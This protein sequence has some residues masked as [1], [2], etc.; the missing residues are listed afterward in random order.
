VQTAR[1]LYELAQQG[2]TVVFATH[3]NALIEQFPGRVFECRGNQLISH[4]GPITTAGADATTPAEAAVGGFP[5]DTPAD[6]PTPDSAPGASPADDIP[7]ATISQ[8]SQE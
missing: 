5:A 1:I 3:N 6:S 8:T 2:T 7:V 4:Q